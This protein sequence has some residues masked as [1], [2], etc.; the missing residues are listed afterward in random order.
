MTQIF[1]VLT[2]WA[3]WDHP[4]RKQTIQPTPIFNLHS[5]RRKLLQLRCRTSHKEF[6]N[7]KR[8]IADEITTYTSITAGIH[9]QYFSLYDKIRQVEPGNS[10]A[11]IWKIP[12]VMFAFDSAKLARLYPIPSLNRPKSFVSPFFRTHPHGYNFFVKF[13]PYDIGPATST[14]ASLLFTLLPGDYD[15]F[16]LQ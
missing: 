1:V 8:K 7:W 9:S 5:I 10:N 6:A 15:N 2:R 4:E 3:L 14:C 12:S 13:H 11:I 16:L